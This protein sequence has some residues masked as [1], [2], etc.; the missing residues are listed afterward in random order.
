[1][2]IQKKIQFNPTFTIVKANARAYC[3]NTSIHG[4]SY[5]ITAPRLLEKFF[6]VIVVVFGLICASLIINTAV[7]DWQDSPTVTVIKSF[8]KV[9]IKKE[10][11]Y[12]FLLVLFHYIV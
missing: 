5:W 8:S 11:V 9:K 10:N 4:F 2:V 6:W 12:V 3:E 1:M 7:K